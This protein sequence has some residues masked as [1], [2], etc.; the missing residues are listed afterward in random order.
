MAKTYVYIRVSTDKQEYDRQVF[1]LAQR[2]YTE[3]NCIILTE[4]YSAKTMVRPVLQ[5]MLNAIEEDDVIV[6][7][8]LSRLARS[9]K[10]LLDILEIIKNKKASLISLKENVDMTTPVGKLFLTM[11]GAFNQFERDNTAQRTKESLRAKKDKGMILGRPTE[12]AKEDIYELLARNF[13]VRDIVE[14]T[15]IA[16]STVYYYA[17]KWREQNDQ[18]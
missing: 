10:D 3:E 17:R 16:Q 15:G 8:A 9:T 5:S 13:T 4:T 18:T 1:L 7:E 14:M 12:V 11:I 2:G 6:V